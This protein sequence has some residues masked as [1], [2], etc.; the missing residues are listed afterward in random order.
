M[1][2]TS[3][4]RRTTLRL[5]YGF[6]MMIFIVGCDGGDSVTGGGGGGGCV[7][8]TCF[9]GGGGGGG[10]SQNPN[11]SIS[12]V[13]GD[14]QNTLTF[15]LSSGSATSFN[16]YWS[17]SPDTTAANWTKI[18]G[19][20]SPFTHT[21]LTNGT[22]LFYGVTAVSGGDESDPSAVVGG[23]PGK[24]TAL[25]PSDPPPARDSHT[26]VY[27]SASKRMIIFG[28]RSSA[29]QP[30]NDY[31][32]LQNADTANVSWS[33]LPTSSPQAR[34]GHTAI[35]NEQS[36][37]MTIFG[38]ALNSNGS[39]LTNELWRVAN[40]D[41]SPTWSPLGGAGPSAR[42]GQAAVYDQASDIMILFG[43]STGTGQGMSNE[44]WVL[45][46]ATTLSP[47]W[48]P[49]P[50]SGGPS[51][52]CCMAVAYD[53]DNRRMIIFGGSGFGQS[54]PI[55]FGDLWTLTFDD[56][57]FT[58]ATWQELTHSGGTAP[59]ARCCAAS[60]WDGDKL[61]LFGGGD[62]NSATD[63]KIYALVLESS[64]FASADGPA[65]G[66][67]PR[68]FPTAVPAGQFLLF[69]GVMGSTSLNDLWRLE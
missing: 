45:D 49:V 40:A 48:R 46:R 1:K 9:G 61:L 54:G 28:G 7:G 62:F 56:A 44:V 43:G 37:A 58:T 11:L 3:I 69:G 26:A 4:Q 53:S 65:E 68:T 8:A 6:I 34:L 36:K 51:V 13:P 17:A 38:G 52:R 64:T 30:L 27:D 35:Y 18:E 33:P 15:A 20:T 24:W 66:P 60:L 42:W 5:L 63:D 31:W 57:G 14:G 23:M 12:A 29:S 16:I 59:S 19:A 2:S 21:G 39:S 32:V 41:T 50:T 22:P 67:D 47:A 55:Q 10:G 25:S